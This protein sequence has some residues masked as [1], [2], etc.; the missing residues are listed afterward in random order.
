MFIEFRSVNN[1]STPITVL[2]PDMP[3]K[4]MDKK[5]RRNRISNKTKMD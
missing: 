2:S 1:L 3:Q 5:K 4:E